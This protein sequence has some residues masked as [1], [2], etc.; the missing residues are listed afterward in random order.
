MAKFLQQWYQEKAHTHT[1]THTHTHYR[2][3]LSY[4][5]CYIKTQI[6]T[7]NCCY[8]FYTTPD[9]QHVETRSV[10]KQNPLPSTQY[11]YY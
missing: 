3:T 7:P 11:L 8:I 1:H 5:Y 6:I 4:L 2:S 9:G 10:M